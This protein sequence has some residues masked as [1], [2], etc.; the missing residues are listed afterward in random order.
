MATALLN[1]R[2]FEEF[3]YG[4]AELLDTRQ[5][6]EWLSL[7]T[8]D[9]VYWMPAG[10]DDID[11]HKETSLIFDDRRALSERVARLLHPAAHSQT[12]PSRTRHLISNVRHQEIEKDRVRLYSNFAVL[13]SRLGIQRWWGGNSEHD[14]RREDGHWRIRLKKV[15]LINNDGVLYYNL[16]FMV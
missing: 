15:C 16:T 10:K 11:P 5:Y 13:E 9:G 8:E 1:P 14:L 12:P 3:L 6:P 2:E 7:F 4:E